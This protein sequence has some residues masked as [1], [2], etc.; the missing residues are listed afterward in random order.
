VTGFIAD[1]S[2][3]PI[4]SG[5]SA[6]IQNG[7]T[8]FTLPSALGVTENQ[9][10]RLLIDSNQPQANLI[11]L[12][13]GEMGSGGTYSRGSA[14][15]SG[16]PDLDFDFHFRVWGYDS[17]SITDE[18]DDSTP[19]DQTVTPGTTPSGK[20]TKNTGTTASD[21]DSAN[22]DQDVP[23]AP[24]NL[25]ILN[26]RITGVGPNYIDLEWDPVD[27]DDLSGYILKYGT[28]SGEYSTEIDVKSNTYHRIEGLKRFETYYIIVYSY[29]LTGNISIPSNE[30]ST[31]LIE[32]A[33]NNWWLWVAFGLVLILIILVI[34][35]L[36][37]R[38]KKKGRENKTEAPA[39]SNLK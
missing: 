33:N 26:L 5:I 21:L 15:L 10:Y 35:F 6:T 19:D 7:W 39:P 29:D 13:Y 3:N 12:F 2:N 14:I 32:M 4:I 1:S 37:K 18:T 23:P 28:R 27:A 34:F 36:W 20:I 11:Y 22:S 30:V 38:K 31:E 8:A 25:K 9:E 16:T 17:G 24:V